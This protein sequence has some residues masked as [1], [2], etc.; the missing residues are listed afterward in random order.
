MLSMEPQPPF[1]GSATIGSNKTT[2]LSTP[3]SGRRIGIPRR[4][5][6]PPTP[7]VAQWIGITKA[8]SFP[9]TL[10]NT[11]MSYPISSQ[12][13]TTRT[14]ASFFD[15]ELGL[16]TTLFSQKHHSPR[17]TPGSGLYHQRRGG[18]TNIRKQFAPQILRKCHRR[19]PAPH[20]GHYSPPPSKKP[21]REKNTPG[22]FPHRSL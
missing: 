6:R 21:Q 3:R 17:Q 12:T 5:G 8:R 22:N 14:T 19:E 11:T 15:C 16:N 4:T 1:A 13:S 7:K 2:Y 10:S 18:I 9:S 20:G